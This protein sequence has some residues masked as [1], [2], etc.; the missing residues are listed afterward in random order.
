MPALLAALEHCR[1]FVYGRCSCQKRACHIKRRSYEIYTVRYRIL[2]KLAKL[3]YY[4]LTRLLVVNL[5]WYVVPDSSVEGAHDIRVCIWLTNN[6][7]FPFTRGGRERGRRGVGAE[8]PALL[9]T[10]S[11]CPDALGQSGSQEL[12]CIYI[13]MYIYIHIYTYVYIHIYN[14]CIYIYTHIV[15]DAPDEHV[16]MCMYV[17]ICMSAC[18][19]AYIHTCACTHIYIYIYIEREREKRE[20]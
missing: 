13:Y 1:S 16:C 8:R 17:Y 19:Y 7:S 3:N 11:A 20:R 9:S 2:V 6:R 14:I 4:S 15:Y 5:D 10:E 18:V 12:I